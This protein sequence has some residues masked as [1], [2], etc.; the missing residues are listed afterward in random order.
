MV[1]NLSLLAVAAFAVLP[2][3]AQQDPVSCARMCTSNMNAA[4][5]ALGC[6]PGDH[7]CLCQ[8][9]NY[10]FGIRDCTNQACPGANAAQAVQ[11]ALGNCP[12]TFGKL[13]PLITIAID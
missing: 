13:I 8:N 7:G 2:S 9:Q 11:D 4:A 1:N 5:Q 10:Q 3:L 6:A 12:S